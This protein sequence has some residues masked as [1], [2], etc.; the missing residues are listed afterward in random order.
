NRIE[1]VPYRWPHGES[2]IPVAIVCDVTDIGRV[3]SHPTTHM[4]RPR[5]NKASSLLIPY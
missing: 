5:I 2:L 3:L 1:V 4:E